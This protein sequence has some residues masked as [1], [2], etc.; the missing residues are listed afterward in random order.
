MTAIGPPRHDAVLFDLDGVL[1]ATASVHAAAWKRAFDEFL[2]DWTR[3][4][5][6]P[7]APFSVERDYVAHVDGKR[8]EDGV[9][10]FMASRGVKLPEGDAGEPW[11]V[12]GIA[13]RK[14]GYVEEVL[15]RDGVEA[16]PGSVRWV[17]QLLRS[18]ARTAVVSSSA[19]CGQ[20]L[21]A[22]RIE[23]LFE[24]IVDGNDVRRLGLR[25]KPAPDGF[26]EAARRLDVAPGRAVVV[27]DALAGVSAGRSGG[28]GLVIGVA[29]AA[30][31]ADLLAA[32]A[33]V[34]VDDLAELAA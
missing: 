21:R 18:G 30:G 3:C 27:E 7:H 4:G 26:L 2:S 28:F 1:T 32:G 22:A 5:L 15:E 34:V 23:E 14:Q 10:A 20:V 16:F 11:S 17:H 9:R 13:H 24:L 19:N 33:D 25:G 29:R 31:H 6:G 12:R 8:R